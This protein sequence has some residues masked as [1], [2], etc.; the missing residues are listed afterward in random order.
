MPDQNMD[1]PAAKAGAQVARARVR[2]DNVGSRGDQ[3]YLVR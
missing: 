3:R 2:R 1:F